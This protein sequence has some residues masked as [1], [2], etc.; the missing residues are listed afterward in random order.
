MKRFFAACLAAIVLLGMCGCQAAETQ[1]QTTEPETFPVTEPAAPT[2]EPQKDTEPEAPKG[3]LL[4]SVSAL[5]LS[6]VGDS[7][8][9]YRGTADPSQILWESSDESIILIENGV[10]TAAGVGTATVRAEFDGKT[11]ECA[12][13]CLAENQEALEQVPQ[14]VL[15]APKRLPQ[16]HEDTPCTFYDDAAFVGDSIAYT[17]QHRAPVTG[18][19]GSPTFLVRGGVSLFGFIIGSKKITLRG[20]ETELEDAIQKSGVNKVF[21]MLGQ[22][23]LSYRSVD[24]TMVTWSDVLE[25]IRS[26]NPDV[27]IYIQSLVPEWN[28]PYKSNAKNEKIDEYNLRLQTFAAENNCHYVEV[29]AYFKDN[30][31]RMPTEYSSDKTIH[32]NAHGADVW[33]DVL[34]AYALELEAKGEL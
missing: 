27:E 12:V 7:E 33:M 1:P 5:T 3:R 16:P 32:I 26:K 34:R 20:V 24:E 6:L 25:R 11:L 2:T 21:I 30:A 23:D 8:D 14:A 28:E 13:T 9:I 29:A 31:N 17:L 4:L 19:I 22:N 10:V 15:R 18:V